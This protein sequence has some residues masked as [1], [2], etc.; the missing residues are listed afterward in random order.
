MRTTFVAGVEPVE[1]AVASG[2]DQ[3]QVRDIFGAV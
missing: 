1:I 3:Q 2:I